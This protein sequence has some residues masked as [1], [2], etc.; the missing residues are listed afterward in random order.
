MASRC[1][2]QE[3]QAGRSTRPSRPG[4]PRT[5]GRFPS[6]PFHPTQA[7]SGGQRPAKA[8]GPA[9][10]YLVPTVRQSSSVHPGRERR[11]AQVLSAKSPGKKRAP[12]ASVSSMGAGAGAVAR[13]AACSGLAARRLSPLSLFL[14][15][16][17]P[18]RPPPPGPRQLWPPARGA[19][20]R[21]QRAGRDRRGQE[22]GRGLAARLPGPLSVT[23]GAFRGLPAGRAPGRDERHGAHVSGRRI[24]RVVA[25]CPHPPSVVAS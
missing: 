9:L 4:P 22:L 17:G 15:S 11:S 23:A 19:P 18:A 5:E 14:T 13:C 12:L 20:P 2:E 3:Q 7:R 6:P 16:A 1:P 25:V 21:D 8:G 24:G 10:R